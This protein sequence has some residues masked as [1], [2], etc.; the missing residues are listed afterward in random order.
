LFILA[1]LFMACVGG[2]GFGLRRF[3][4]HTLQREHLGPRS[5]E[6]TLHQHPTR[7]IPV[8]GARVLLD[9]AAFGIAIDHPPR[10]AP[11]L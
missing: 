4:E 7:P 10:A 5:F 6:G 9:C 11:H 8:V 2:S 1:S 3:I